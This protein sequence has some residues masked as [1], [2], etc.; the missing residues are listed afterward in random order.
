[1]KKEENILGYENIKTLMKKFSIPCIIS[2]VVNA[3]YNIVDQ[4]YIGW[5][6]GYLGN[7]ATNIIFPITVVALAFAL[8]LGDGTSAY[9]SLKLGEKKKDEAKKGVCNGIISSV[10][11]SLLLCIICLIFLP[12]LIYLFGCTKALKKFALEYG[13]VIALGLPF[14]MIGTTL[15]SIIRADGSPKYAMTSMVT[16]AILNI[17]LDPIFIF[18]FHM[19]VEGAAI[20]TIISQIVTFIMNIAYLRKF[21]SITLTKKDYKFNLNITKNIAMLGISSFIT[22]MSIVIVIAV[23]N[24]MLA[25]YGVYSKYGTEIPITV[26]GIVMKI[27]QI[28]NSIIIG[29]AAGSQ[30]IIGYNYGAS[31]YKRVKETLKYVIKVSLFVGLVAFI[32]FQTIPEQLISIFGSGSK[33]Y[34]EFACLTFRIMLLLTICNSVQIVSGI[35]FQAIGKSGKSAFLSLSRQI[36]FL[37]PA[38]IIM[39]S[40]I[41]VKGVLYAGPIADG[42][43]FIISVILLIKETK[44]LNKKEVNITALSEDIKESNILKNKII[45]T[46]AREYGSGGRYVGRL[47]AQKLGIKFYDKDIMV[48]LAEKT[49][50][51]LDYIESNEQKRDNIANISSNIAGLTTQDNLY[52]EESKL[53]KSLSSSSCVII[54]RCADDILKDEKNILKVFI[55]SDMDDKIKRVTTHYNIDKKNALKE[56][57]RINKLRSNHYKHYTGKNWGMPDNYDLCIN[58]DLLG[59]EKTAEI[60]SDMAIAKAEKR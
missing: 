39:S 35:F 19:G 27:N 58:S 44:N 29:I 24:N 38:M 54:G 49:G 37:I 51:S 12:K 2:L 15:N 36:L 50:L 23:Q 32:L 3:L 42:L 5:G 52:L 59:V 45:I 14:V 20:A 46:I 40:I 16:G 31:N 7:G 48:K 57:K 53:I 60:I 41:G 18:V 33:L 47:V 22:Q 8:M 25:K 21:K 1:M 10:I 9:L 28:L 4:I 55:Y 26:I 13:Y 43:A 17:I 56:I 6:V 11:V 30:P 34:N